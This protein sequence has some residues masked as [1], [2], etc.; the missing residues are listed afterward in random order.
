MP[1]VN[2]AIIFPDDMIASINFIIDSVGVIL[3]SVQFDLPKKM[4][5][6]ADAFAEKVR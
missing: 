4:K 6:S 5:Y 2:D 3:L 1:N